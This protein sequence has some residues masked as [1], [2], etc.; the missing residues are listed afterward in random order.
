M[1]NAA[2]FQGQADIGVYVTLVDYEAPNVL[3]SQMLLLAGR[4]PTGTN[5]ML[6]DAT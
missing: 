5:A 1:E 6:H 3:W 4:A 2:E